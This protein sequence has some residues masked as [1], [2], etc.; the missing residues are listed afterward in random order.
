MA[1]K[2]KTLLWWLGV[3]GVKTTENKIYAPPSKFH[4][5]T[6][7]MQ[8]RQ[9]Q[10]DE[11]DYCCWNIL[12]LAII[13]FIKQSRGATTDVEITKKSKNK[14]EYMYSLNSI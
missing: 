1:S 13:S 8:T 4:Q 10:S 7:S 2:S 12:T 9:R 6:H 3:E 14:I 11:K 5:L